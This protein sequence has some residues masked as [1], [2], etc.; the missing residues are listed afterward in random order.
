MNTE[1]L[2]H[3]FSNFGSAEWFAIAIAAAL[4]CSAA[5][6]YSFSRRSIRKPAAGRGE[7]IRTFD[8]LVPNQA[9]YQAKLRPES[10]AYSMRKVAHR[11][12]VSTVSSPAGAA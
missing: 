8:L 2:F 3:F 7:R 1:T 12:P 4:L 9:L 5:I 10:P 11:R 6:D